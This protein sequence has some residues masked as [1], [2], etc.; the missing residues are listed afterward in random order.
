MQPRT[1]YPLDILQHV[2]DDDATVTLNNQQNMLICKAEATH[3]VV[4]C[5]A[6][7]LDWVLVGAH[8]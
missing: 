6:Y 1:E 8:I 5:V 3:V 7:H 4:L 2:I